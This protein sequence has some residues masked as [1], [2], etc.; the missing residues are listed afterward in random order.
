MIEQ[1]TVESIKSAIA[2]GTLTAEEV[3]NAAIEDK[4]AQQPGRKG[5]RPELWRHAHVLG[6]VEILKNE[7][8]TGKAIDAVMHHG[9]LINR[10]SFD[11]LLKRARDNW[12]PLPPF[13]PTIQIVDG[14]KQKVRSIQLY[15]RHSSMQGYLYGLW[16]FVDEWWF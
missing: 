6:V 11:E 1:I 9:D 2:D 3:I 8:G 15:C 10:K 14:K 7:M 5:R 12:T 13:E 4:P 16:I